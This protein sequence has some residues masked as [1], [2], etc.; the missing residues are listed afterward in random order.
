MSA[1]IGRAVNRVEDRVVDQIDRARFPKKPRKCPLT[2]EAD[3]AFHAMRKERGG[4]WA[5][6]W[7]SARAHWEPERSPAPERHRAEAA[8]RA[9]QIGGDE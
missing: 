6:S 7:A 4:E 8:F 2:A 3:R 9:L 5:R 1:H